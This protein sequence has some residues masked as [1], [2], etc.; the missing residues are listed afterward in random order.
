VD[1]CSSCMIDFDCDG[2]EEDL[3]DVDGDTI[4]LLVI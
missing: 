4:M 2:D 3:M 1:T